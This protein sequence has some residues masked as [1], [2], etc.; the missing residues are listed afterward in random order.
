MMPVHILVAVICVSLLSIYISVLAGFRTKMDRYVCC[1]LGYLVVHATHAWVVRIYFIEDMK[2][3]YWAPYGLLYGPFLYFAYQ[4]AAGTP[5]KVKRVLL[6]A[7]P[8]LF[9]LVCYFRWLA[10]PS[11]FGDHERL[12]GLSLYGTLSLSLISYA[13]WAL[14][15]RSESVD[16]NRN[17]ESRMVSTMAMVLAFVAVV[18]L[19]ITYSN[20]ASGPIRSHFKGS[21]VFASMLAAAVVLFS[22]IIK[23]VVGGSDGKKAIAFPQHSLV[24]P[25][26][27]GAA[28]DPDRSV[29]YQKSAIPSDILEVYEA[30]LRRLVEEKRIYLDDELSLASLAQ[31]LKMPKHHL[32][33][34]FSL[35]IG[36]NFN[37]YI[38]EHR[39]NHA[40][41]LMH[42]HPE[43]GVRDIFLGSGFTAKASFN[44]YFKQ[45]RE[46]TPTEYRNGIAE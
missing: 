3:D 33:Q 21:I 28:S 43:M 16:I 17:E 27:T 32:S 6:H 31:Q 23:R 36:K 46:C 10:A 42:T 15:F 38:N 7:L 24:P 37:T 5:M 39:V 34:V 41:K 14:F 35:R 30:S 20:V 44:R 8:F 25:I 11:L 45:F 26:G 29:R 19:V 9:F 13:V 40:V 12:F 2:L 4:V 1:F 22:Y 18:L